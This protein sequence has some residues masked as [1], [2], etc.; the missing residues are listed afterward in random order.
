MAAPPPV[1]P[2]SIDIPQIGAHSSLLPIGINPKT[3]ELAEPDVTHPQ[4]AVYYCQTDV[5]PAT[6]CKSGVVPGQA[7]PS[8]IIGH[9]DG[10]VVHGAHQEG[11]FFHLHELRIGDKV[12]VTR[13]DGTVLNYTVYR[14]IQKPKPQ[15]PTQEVY[16]YT[17]TSE[18]RLIT[19][20]GQFI[21]GQFGYADNTIVF[22]RPA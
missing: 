6:S 5:V 19:C 12:A 2:A 11:I 15:F 13:V 18:L 10:S 8:I 3:K 17:P 22:A 16:G 9:V 4:Q 1:Q 7:G 20:S 14:L 21:G